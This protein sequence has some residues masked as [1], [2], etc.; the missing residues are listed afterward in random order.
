MSNV[1]KARELAGMIVNEKQAD[2]VWSDDFMSV[3]NTEEYK[4][5]ESKL[6]SKKLRIQSSK[7]YLGETDPN[8]PRCAS[9]YSED[10]RLKPWY[11][12]L[13]ERFF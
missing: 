8:A 1:I 2:T 3:R 11:I 6:I 12:R 9:S 10:S 4:K 7:K 13:K 5:V